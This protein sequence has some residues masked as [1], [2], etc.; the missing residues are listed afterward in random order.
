M[1]FQLPPGYIALG[2]LAALLTPGCGK[3]VRKPLARC[4][5]AG[6]WLV[7]LRRQPSEVVATG[8]RGLSEHCAGAALRYGKLAGKALERGLQ[9]SADPALLEYLEIRSKY[10]QCAATRLSAPSA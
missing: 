1:L 3:A 7:S 4:A 8:R 6:A 10:E 9:L 5:T 2:K